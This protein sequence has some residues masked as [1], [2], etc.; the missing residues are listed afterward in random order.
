MRAL[1]LAHGG[2]GMNNLDLF[3]RD[4]GK[5]WKIGIPKNK[6]SLPVDF[7]QLKQLGINRVKARIIKMLLP[8]RNVDY[9]I[10]KANGITQLY[11]QESNKQYDWRMNAMAFTVKVKMGGEYRRYHA[12]FYL[13][14]LTI[15][16]DLN[17]KGLLNE[18]IL[19]VFAYSLGAAS[20]MPFAA[21]IRN[22][23]TSTLYNN[24]VIG[25]ESPRCIRRPSADSKAEA[26][27]DIWYKQGNDMVC[28][29]PWWMSHL[30][31]K[32]QI[33]GLKLPVYLLHLSPLLNHNIYWT[34]PPELNKK[35]EGLF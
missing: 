10:N 6:V 8:S 30:G 24:R 20:L 5:M 19:E 2:Y 16:N 9:F 7:S 23:S 31:Q 29:V 1:I 33:K 21:M 22:K 27:N 25:F 34:I 13:T 11:L 4:A 14:A 17:R 28:N 3:I 32:R 26:Q 18:Q 35:V 12:G 15:F